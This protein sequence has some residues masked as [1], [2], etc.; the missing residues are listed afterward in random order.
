MNYDE[1]RTTPE[2]E[3]RRQATFKR[4]GGRC[5]LCNSNYKIQCHH[6]T[7]KRI[8]HESPRDLQTLCGLCH[9]LYSIAAKMSSPEKGYYGSIRVKRPRGMP[10]PGEPIEETPV[11]PEDEP[12]ET[13]DDEQMSDE[14]VDALLDDLYKKLNW[15][16]RK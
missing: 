7:Y 15:G 3:Y 2:W 16:P 13:E 10:V 14:D 8:G 11:E 6:R 12:D 9:A 5:V 4:D 1:Y